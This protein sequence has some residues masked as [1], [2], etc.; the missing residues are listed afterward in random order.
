MVFK[1]QTLEYVSERFGGRVE[2]AKRFYD[3]L[4]KSLNKNFKGRNLLSSMQQ[5][6]DFLFLGTKDI[7]MGRAGKN[8][9]TK[10]F[11]LVRILRY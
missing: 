2:L 9:N 7:S 5:C 6:N 11:P 10:L 3:G 1:K 4:S 8:L